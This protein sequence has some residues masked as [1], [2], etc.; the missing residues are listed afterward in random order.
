MGSVWTE[1]RLR[2]LL[3]TVAKRPDFDELLAKLNA[4]PGVRIA[5]S[6]ALRA[7]WY[8]VRKQGKRRADWTGDRQVLL[9]T[10]HRGGVGLEEI[11][12]RLNC[13]PGQ[14]ILTVCAIESKLARIREGKSKTATICETGAVPVPETPS[15]TPGG[16]L[17]VS[18]DEA[19]GWAKRAGLLPKYQGLNLLL[20]NRVRRAAGLP[21]F[22]LIGAM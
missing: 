21:Q 1:Q 7:K 19:K 4:M 18:Y 14:P 17:M 20:I 12:T 16:G 2:L 6:Y 9:E 5:S 22:A 10:L 8:E 13:L 3:S 11:R 15:S